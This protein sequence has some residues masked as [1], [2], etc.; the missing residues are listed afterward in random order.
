MLASFAVYIT[1]NIRKAPVDTLTIIFLSAVF[2]KVGSLMVGLAYGY[3]GYRLFLADKTKASGDFQANA[4]KYAL[5]LKGG[6]PGIFFSLFGTAVIIATLVTRLEYQGSS[7]L[8]QPGGGVPN[9]LPSDSFG[10]S[11]VLK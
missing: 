9:V 10:K 5:S 6:A 4:G 8:T 2:F 11:G 7:K 1:L 3:M